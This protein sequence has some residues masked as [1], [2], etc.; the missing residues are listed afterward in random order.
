MGSSGRYNQNQVV[1][2]VKTRLNA[3]T[4]LFAFYVLSKAMSNTDG[5]NTFA[6]NPYDSRGEYGPAATDVRHRITA[7][8]SA[9]MRWGVRVSPYFI[10]QSGA[11]FNITSGNDAYGTTLFNS[12]PGIATDPTRPG[13]IPTRYGLLDPNPDRPRNCS[14]ATTVAVPL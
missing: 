6:A 13:L 11:P 3:G 8:G 5:V 4:S 14:D 7:G 9:A 1:A 2:N 10:I 12:R